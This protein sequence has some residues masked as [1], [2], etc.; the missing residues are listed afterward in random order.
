[1]ATVSLAQG[2]FGGDRL[3]RIRT[4]REQLNPGEFPQDVDAEPERTSI[5]CMHLTQTYNSLYLLLNSFSSRPF[6]LQN[7]TNIAR[8][9]FLSFL[10]VERSNVWI[11]LFSIYKIYYLHQNL[12]FEYF[13]F[14]FT[15]FIIYIKIWHVPSSNVFPCM[16]FQLNV[17]IHNIVSPKIGCFCLWDRWMATVKKIP[18][19]DIL[20]FFDPAHWANEL[21][22][23]TFLSWMEGFSRG[24]AF[25]YF[26]DDWFRQQQI[27]TC[28]MQQRIN[29]SSPRDSVALTR[30]I[31][32]V[33]F[34]CINIRLYIPSRSSNHSKKFSQIK[35]NK[36]K[37]E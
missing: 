27:I 12:T 13:F 20:I 2:V 37:I 32:Q 4:E 14:L 18:S 15:K 34:P 10:A 26:I 3:A 7:L 33:L 9:S 17:G 36:I 25:Q 28:V 8:I 11:F 30:L 21:Q 1:M 23:K 22:E 24:V 6:V 5:S 16:R 31:I 19:I 35:W 29:E